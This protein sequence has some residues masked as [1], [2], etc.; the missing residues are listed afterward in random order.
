MVQ[1]KHESK[2][3]A[4]HATAVLKRIA[5]KSFSCLLQHNRK[6][7]S[8]DD[9]D[10]SIIKSLNFKTWPMSRISTLLGCQTCFRKQLLMS[11]LLKPFIGYNNSNHSGRKIEAP[12]QYGKVKEAQGRNL[13][14]WLRGCKQTRRIVQYWS[15]V[16][17]DSIKKMIPLKIFTNK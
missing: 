10:I 5:I 12:L 6:V 3:Y 9:I 7:Q 16:F 17:A 8:L 11:R 4:L 2:E 1:K 15:S 13:R 14:L